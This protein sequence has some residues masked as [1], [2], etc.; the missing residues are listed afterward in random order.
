MAPLGNDT[1]C[2]IIQWFK[3]LTLC[4][5]LKLGSLL[6]HLTALWSWVSYRTSLQSSFIIYITGISSTYILGLLCGLNKLIHV[7]HLVSFFSH[8][9]C[10]ANVSHDDVDV[11]DNMMMMM[12]NRLL[13]AG[14]LAKAFGT[15]WWTALQNG[16]SIYS[17]V[18]SRVFY[19][20]YLN[21]A[22]MSIFQKC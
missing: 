19:W 7:K 15:H 9:K 20:K 11:D 18:G 14:L 21:R 2:T 16:V 3:V 1:S 5:Q 8:S 10:V 17:P 4:R 13:V 12:T 22:Y 6:F